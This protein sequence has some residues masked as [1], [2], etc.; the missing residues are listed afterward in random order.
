MSVTQVYAG[1]GNLIVNGNL[2]LGTV[3]P[4]NPFVVSNGGAAGLEIN[5][6]GNYIPG[7]INI[8]G[9]N[10]STSTYTDIDFITTGYNNS[11]VI[12]ASSGNVGV[13][14]ATPENPFV[15]SNGGAAGLE[16]NPTGN[17][18]PGGTNIL[19][20]NRSTSTYTDIDFIT[21]GYNNSLVIKASSGNVGIGT[22]TP[23]YTLDVNGTI[24]GSNVSPSDAKFKKNLLPITAPL[25]KV[26][27]INGHSYEWKTDEYKSK[28][29]PDGR[30]YGVIAQEIE[31]VLPE[32]VNTDAKGEKSVAYTEIIPVLIEA[33][34]EQQTMITS[35]QAI[36]AQ[37][38][39]LLDQQ[40]K[41]LVDIHK[42][43]LKNSQTSQTPQTMHY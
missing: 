3:T 24:R 13:G 6:T 17:Y 21:T 23:A 31:K 26:L 20:Y 27:G 12:K 22:T 7:G 2:G 34:K 9:Y 32:V 37:Q 28:N 8:L 25:D 42:M 18:I 36:I 10:R 15:I 40:Q 35:L 30:H 5:P 4:E 29:F 43:L 38:Q 33:V 14:T 16:I 19:G 1:N 39:T 41:Q 11:L